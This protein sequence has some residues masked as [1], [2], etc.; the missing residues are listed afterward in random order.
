M[1]CPAAALARASASLN[2]APLGLAGVGVD[3]VDL[4]D[5][6]QLIE[7][8][9][10]AFLESAWTA[11]EREECVGSTERLAA[12]WAAKEA[13]MKALGEGLG[14]LS[15]LDIDVRLDP[16]TG[17]PRVQLYRHALSRAHDQA[18]GGWFVSLCHENGWAAAIAVATR[19]RPEAT[20]SVL[21]SVVHDDDGREVT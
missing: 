4:A 14:Q 10:T 19:E 18:I 21:K 17:A 9:G 11:G 7:A 6:E 20:R 2:V 3:L 5:V 8:G 12:R 15:P 13:V 16:D 1:T